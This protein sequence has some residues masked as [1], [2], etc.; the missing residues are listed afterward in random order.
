MHDTAYSNALRFFNKYCKDIESKIVLDVGSFD[1][2]GTLKPIFSNSKKYIGLDQ[3]PGK[4]VD[5]VG[6]SHEI[7]LDD[8]SV[9][10]TVSSSCFEHDNMFWITFKEM[11]RVLRPSGYI[12]INAPSNGPYHK[13]PVDNWRFYLDSWKA[14]EQWG[15]HLNFDIVLLEG[16]IDSQKSSCGNWND[17][18]G[19]Y[20]KN[21]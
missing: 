21:S 18:V 13:Y 6:S 16:Y 2:N 1:V 7:P 8:N 15:R 3:F 5:V 20:V 19:I 11:C 10:V 4:N 12:Y 17:S 9:D 14:L